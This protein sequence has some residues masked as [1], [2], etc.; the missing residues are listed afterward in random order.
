LQDV[1]RWVPPSPK[2][3]DP[4][5]LS[6]WRDKKGATGSVT[7]DQSEMEMNNEFDTKWKWT[8]MDSSAV[9]KNRKLLDE[10]QDSYSIH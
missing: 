2:R 5:L 9:F 8:M 1:P 3:R 4:L 7:A 6:Q 10:K